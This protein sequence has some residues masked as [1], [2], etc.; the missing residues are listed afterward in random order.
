MQGAPVST[1][2]LDVVH[3]RSEENIA[4]LLLVLRDLNATYRNDSRGLPANES[5]LRSS[6][7]QLLAT[8]LGPLDVRG[9]IGDGSGHDDLIGSTVEMDVR[10]LFVRVLS[11]ERLIAEKKRLGRPKDMSALPALVATLEE[12]R[13]RRP[14]PK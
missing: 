13:A 7:H 2:D 6:G 9:T 12:I 10:G 8:R 5:H 14:D 4:R 3:H 11:L 1:F